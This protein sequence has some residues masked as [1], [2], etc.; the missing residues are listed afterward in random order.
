M[1]ALESGAAGIRTL[2]RRLPPGTHTGIIERARDE[3][4]QADDYVIDWQLVASPANPHACPIELIA[5]RMTGG[6]CAWG[7][8]F[9]TR[10]R[11]AQVLGVKQDRRGAHLIAF[12]TEPIIM[13]PDRVAAI[14]EAVIS[15]RV[16]LYYRSLAGRL[17]NTRGVVLVPGIPQRFGGTGMPLGARK[18]FRYAPWSPVAGLG[19]VT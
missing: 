4:E 7:F 13:P 1:D 3:I 5:S 12:G 19:A 16:E 15:G 11:I 8:F 17:M 10:G 18:V 9:D 14:V 2:I 6:S